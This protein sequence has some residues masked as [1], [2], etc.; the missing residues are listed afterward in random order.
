M[1]QVRLDDDYRTAALQRAQGKPAVLIVV[2]G[3]VTGAG[4]ALD[5]A[6]RGLS[7]TLVEA[8]DFAAGTSSRSSKLLHG[9][10]RYLEQLDLRLVTDALRERNLQLRTIAP[11]LAR[12][13]P[14]LLPL[15]HAGRDRAYLGLGVAAYGT[16]ARIGDDRLLPGHRHLGRAGAARIAPS[17]D[18]T[19][20]HGAVRYY[21][22]QVDDARHTL[23]LV[24]TAATYGATVLNRMRVTSLLRDGDRVVGVAA[25][26]TETGNT[27]SLRSDV[28]INAAGPWAP[29]VDNETGQPMA[30][31]P[32]KGVHLMVPRHLIDLDGGL[33]SRTA[34]SVLFVIPW[35]PCWLIGTTDTPWDGVDREVTADPDDVT[36][37]LDELNALLRQ[38]IRAADVI[39]TFAGL[40][41]LAGAETSD[42]TRISRD[43]T[44]TTRPGMVTILGG[45]YT[46]Y[47]RMA[48]DA[49]D[50]AAAQLPGNVPPSCT[51]TVPLIGAQGFTAA[52]Q[53]RHALAERWDVDVATAERLL[54]RYGA[55]TGEV[56]APAQRDRTLLEPAEPGSRYLRAEVLY[57]ATHEGARSLQDVLARRTRISLE[58]AS[59]GLDNLTDTGHLIGE[60]L[61][62]DQPRIH[63]EQE[64]YRAWLRNERHALHALD[65]PRGH[66]LASRAGA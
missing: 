53:A 5:A 47:R 28:V 62:W 43:H 63:T 51:K 44:V 39:A 46:T 60:A 6:T 16:L 1:L 10:L 57:A 37:L 45:K 48:S 27:H 21:D 15:Q 33:I 35:G 56:L 12:P 29:S 17:I 18:W 14:F 30:L 38:P 64:L 66:A 34:K 11:H 61:G 59:G 22:A 7:V 26:D 52:W 41:P 36:Y 13:M 3:G 9:G 54:R 58:T 32:S 25:Q 65:G 24:R 2:G 8:T 49:V 20:Y 55:L 23:E 4:I 31:R 19:R 42:T 40:R 50:A